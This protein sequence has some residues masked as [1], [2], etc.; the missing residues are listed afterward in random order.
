MEFYRGQ[1]IDVNL[2]SIDGS[3]QS[4]VRPCIIIGNNTG[5]FYSPILLVVPLTSSTT[6]SKI[7]THMWVKASKIN[8][9]EVDSMALAEQILTVTKKMVVNERGSLTT[10]ELKELDE[11]I[12]ISLDLN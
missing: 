10:N 11:K 7:P 1:I 12:K 3:I 5:N 6:K 2:P 4:G 9:L 8:E